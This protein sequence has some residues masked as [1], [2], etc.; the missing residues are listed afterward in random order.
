[1]LIGI[2]PVLLWFYTGNYDMYKGKGFLSW[3][4][5]KSSHILL[6]FNKLT[7]YTFFKCVSLKHWHPHTSYFT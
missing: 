7:C 3:P 5:R 1:M 2:G 6:D 4:V